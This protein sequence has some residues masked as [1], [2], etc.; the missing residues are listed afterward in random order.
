M[1]AYRSLL[2]VALLLVVASMANAQ[3]SEYQKILNQ[4]C[5]Y[6]ESLYLFD[7]SGDPELI[8]IPLL[9]AFLPS[10]STGN[11]P[12][13]QSIP[14]WAVEDFLGSLNLQRENPTARCV[15][16]SHS[17]LECDAPIHSVDG[18]VDRRPIVILG[19]IEH[20][21]E[22]WSTSQLRISTLVYVRIDEVLKDPTGTLTPGMLVT[23]VRPWG[24]VGIGGVTLCTYPPK[25]MLASQAI[26][27]QQVV[28]AGSLDLRNEHHF[29]TPTDFV[30]RVEGD[31]VLPPTPERTNCFL[32]TSFSIDTL[33][34]LLTK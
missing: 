2:I 8:P 25:G 28:I 15:V 22:A 9:E 26:K 23:H 32:P 16:R 7:A 3:S 24:S 33:R 6:A 30:F 14:R 19:T 10:A 18:V 4:S 17:S 5:A 11:N 13:N 29:V 34:E 20:L 27:D 12:P 31:L 1:R 21:E